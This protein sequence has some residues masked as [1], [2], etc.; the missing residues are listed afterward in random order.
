MHKHINNPSV[1]GK[2]GMDTFWEIVTNT[3]H[4]KDQSHHT[5]K[6]YL[7]K[8][9]AGD[10]KEYSLGATKLKELPQH[11]KTGG[12]GWKGQWS[13]SWGSYGGDGQN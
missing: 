1:Y 13:K 9:K 7:A 6:I 11:L 8:H 10:G 4:S 2:V 12:G 3:T 5:Y